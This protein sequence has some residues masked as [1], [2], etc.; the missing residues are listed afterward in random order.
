MKKNVYFI[1]MLL[2]II[3]GVVGAF[4]QLTI[5]FVN[6]WIAKGYNGLLAHGLPANILLVITTMAAI[7]LAYFLVKIVAKDA[8]GSGIPEIE[9]VL[10]HKLPLVWYRLLPVKFVGGVLSICA[11]M[12]V[13][14]EGP[15]IQMGGNLGEMLSQWFKLT[16]T[17]RDT[18]IAAGAGAGLA[19]A[20]NAP[21]AGLFFV[22]EELRH[23][24]QYSFFNLK[25]VALCCLLA[26]I[27]RNILLGPQPIIIL[28]TLDAIPLESLWM[29]VIFGLLIGLFGIVFNRVLIKSM[30]LMD[31]TTA[32]MHVVFVIFVGLFV[33][34]CSIYYPDWVGDGYEVMFQS[35][36]HSPTLTGLCILLLIRLCTTILCYNTGVPGGIFSPM[37]ALGT[38]FGLAFYH[39]GALISAKFAISSEIWA[40]M[41]MGGLFAASV[42]APLTG[43]VL[44][45]EMTQN[46]TLGLALMVTCLTSAMVMQLT[47]N[48][49][50]YALLLN[51]KLQNRTKL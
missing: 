41:G 21:L 22:L 44:V 38:L 13:G 36:I 30:H 51:R 43:I 19:V 42:R 14:R 17:Y 33:G 50:I 34:V 8:S 45:I 29:F 49:P 26:T 39:V 11:K 48:E 2:G 25:I 20:F 37:I 6:E 12:V 9:G 7:L 28:K 5:A 32:Q 10:S 16:L 18:L 31:K 23:A 15:T 1:S 35:L 40:V 47:K 24:F 4:F 27:T 46:Y 3:T